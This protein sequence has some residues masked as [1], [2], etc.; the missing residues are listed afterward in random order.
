MKIG[1]LV[2]YRDDRWADLVG[3]VLRQI[4]GTDE[5]QIVRWNHSYPTM[6]HQKRN[7]EVVSES[8]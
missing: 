7:L 5:V 1:D 8:A 3:I 4:P 2:R 6:G